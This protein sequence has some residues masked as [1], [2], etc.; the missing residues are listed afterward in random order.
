MALAKYLDDSVRQRVGRDRPISLNFRQVVAFADAVGTKYQG[1]S[2][3]KR[4]ASDVRGA[5]CMAE[6]AWLPDQSS[7]PGPENL[8]V[9]VADLHE[10]ENQGFGVEEA[11]DDYRAG[12]S[13]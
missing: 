6:H 10:S 4:L 11:D 1:I 12:A 7:T 9:N 8:A 2:G 3:E 5:D 13:L